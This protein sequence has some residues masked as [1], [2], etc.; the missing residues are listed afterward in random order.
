MKWFNWHRVATVAATVGAFAAANWIPATLT[1]ALGPLSIPIAATVTAVVTAAAAA[2]IVQSP[3]VAKV[4]S[5][6]KP[7]TAK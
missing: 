7:P 3:T 2:G 5:V 4:L 1:I 6:V